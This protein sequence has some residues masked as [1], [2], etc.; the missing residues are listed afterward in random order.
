MEPSIFK[1]LL[2][3]FLDIS[4][5]SNHGNEFVDCLQVI[6]EYDPDYKSVMSQLPKN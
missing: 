6:S 2:K 3:Y 1:L 5:E 4:K